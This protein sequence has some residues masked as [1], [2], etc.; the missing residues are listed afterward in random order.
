MDYDKNIL[1]WL[2]TIVNGMMIV[3]LIVTNIVLI[4]KVCITK[5]KKWVAFSSIAAIISFTL[6]ASLIF[7]ACVVSLITNDNTSTSLATQISFIAIIMYCI[8]QTIMVFTFTLRIDKTFEGTDLAYSKCVVYGLY[9]AS[10][11]L[12]AFGFS[13]VLCMVFALWNLL[14]LG[15]IVWVF[16]YFGTTILLIVLFIRKIEE[17]MIIRYKSETENSVQSVVSSNSSTQSRTDVN[18]NDKVVK[19]MIHSKLFVLVVKHGVLV[20]IAITSSVICFILDIAT[21]YAMGNDQFHAAASFWFVLDATISC[22][23]IFLLFGFNHGIYKRLCHPLHKSCEKYEL[24]K[25][26]RSNKLK[27]DTQ[28]EM[29]GKASV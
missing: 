26:K 28:T 9:I 12:I 6:T 1:H 8:S 7:T 4:Y 24:W 5:H 27:T 17:L 16:V 3:M 11:I 20:P 13:I 25:L 23:C 22:G 15:A 18:K 29:T 19:A 2:A 14:A 21:W 10:T